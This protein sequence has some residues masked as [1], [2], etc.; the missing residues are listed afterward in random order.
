MPRRPKCI[1]CPLQAGCAARAAGIAEALPARSPKPERPTRRAVAFWTVNPA[2]E[3]L[4]RRRP[5]EGLLGGMMEV[6]STD[7]RE[8]QWAEAEAHAQA[9]L[10]AEWRAL[11]GLVR[12]DLRRW[13]GGR[14]SSFLYH[15]AKRWI[16]PLFI[17]AWVLYLSLPFSIHPAF[18]ILPFAGLIGVLVALTTGSFKKYL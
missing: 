18:A 5:E 16:W 7:W 11:D 17:T 2:G 1:L 6:P 13:G 12:R 9:P 15:H 14:E 10:A 4:L 3:I 8:A